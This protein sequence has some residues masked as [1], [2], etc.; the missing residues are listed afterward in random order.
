M[1]DV[2]FF[3]GMLH[4]SSVSQMM[5]DELYTIALTFAKHLFENFG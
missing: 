4:A 5:L 2:Y 3:T 1:L